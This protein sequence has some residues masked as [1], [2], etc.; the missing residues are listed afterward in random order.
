MARFNREAMFT[1][2]LM[3]TLKC[4]FKQQQKRWTKTIHKFIISPVNYKAANLL[5]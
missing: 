3:Q 4:F 2:G 1:K 5:Q